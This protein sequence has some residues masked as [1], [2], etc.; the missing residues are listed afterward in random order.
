MNN[1]ERVLTILNGG[2]PDRIP[3]LPFSELVPDSSFVQEM[4]K[5]G[6]G[7]ITHCS[8]V[9]SKIEGIEIIEELIDKKTVITYHT[10]IGKLYET[11][12]NSVGKVITGH[13]LGVRTDFL[14]KDVKDYDV[15]IYIIDHTEHFIDEAQFYS[16]DNELLSDGITH[17][18]TD[19]P[20]FMDAQYYLGL[21]N[22]SFHQFDYPEEFQRLL[23]AL[24]R[25]QERRLQLLLDCPDMLINLGNL[26][27]NFGPPQYK[28][29]MLPY[30]EK[31]VPLFK[32]KGK[33]TTIHADANNL[34]EYKE[35]LSK[36][37]VDVIEAFTPPPFGNLS[38][39]EAR[40]AW[41]GEKTIWINFP[42]AV[43]YEGYEYT[44]N[45]T[46]ELLKSELCPNKLLGLTE[47][48]LLG[49]DGENIKVFQDGIR[50]IMDAIDEA[51]EY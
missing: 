43:F 51:G 4:R 6:M 25:R 20:P 41:G 10:P 21:E 17:C 15:A 46:I 45:Y 34:L 13:N 36:T 22:W 29:F 30:Y 32:A 9:G 33:I 28:E 39:A 23:D 1:R 8:S 24:G 38:L 2:T 40:K 50:A 35:L 14:I 31:Y 27:G 11:Y 5:R 7:L 26:A 42:E 48:G 37:G 44:K 18:W 19:E 47:M 49:V 3:F 12:D 16:T